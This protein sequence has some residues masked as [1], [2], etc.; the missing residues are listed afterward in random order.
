M[1][2]QT[3]QG[4]TANIYPVPKPIVW[5]GRFIQFFSVRWAAAYSRYFFMLPQRHRVKP[6]ESAWRE[7]ARQ[8]DMDVPAIGKKVRMYAWGDGD[9]SVLL[10]H[11]W[12]GRGSQFVHLGR[13]LLERGYR[14]VAFDAPAHGQSAGKRTLMLHFI[15]TIKE[16][17][18]QNG[19][20]HALIGH[21]MGGI[22]AL[23]A[24]GSHGVRPAYLVTIGIPDSIKR[25][26]Y[27]FA[28]IMGLKEDIA[29][30]NIEYLARVY[31]S[32]IDRLAGSYNAEKV[33]VPT[34]IIHDRDD[35]EVPYTE[36]LS[37]GRKLPD[38]RLLLT[39]G[40]GHRRIMRNGEVIARILDF[41]EGKEVGQKSATEI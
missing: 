6:A 12:S 7:Q 24:V 15:E 23:N 9:K 39:G 28:R 5:V 2:K 10:A 27:Q 17:D 32:D 18:A 30:L 33:A 11:G 41:L 14:V 26:F 25:I 4:Q 16:A 31:G 20:F 13:S 35:K 3:S 37:I 34:L 1:E 38:G 36:A 29:R 8:W 21:S 40:L 22:A 19:P